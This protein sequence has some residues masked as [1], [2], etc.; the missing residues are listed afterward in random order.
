LAK[1]DIIILGLQD[2]EGIPESFNDFFKALRE[3][4]K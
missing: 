1:Q 4:Y 3:L 2:L